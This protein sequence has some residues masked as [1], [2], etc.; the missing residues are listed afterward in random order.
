MPFLEEGVNYPGHELPP[1]SPN[2]DL[3]VYRLLNKVASKPSGKR[4]LFGFQAPRDFIFR[5]ELAEL[6]AHNANLRV[7]VT[8]SRP[9]EEP[10]S[11]AVGRIDAALLAAAVPDIAKRRAHVCGPPPMMDAVKAALVELGMPEAQIRT[12]AFGTI[13]RDPTAKGAAATEV[14]GQVVFQASDMTVPVPVGATILDAAD[15]A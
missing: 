6:E 8:M 12:E 15:E 2:A 11:G 10:W 14:A 1:R 3:C 5:E 13:Q 4:I 7:T 9:G